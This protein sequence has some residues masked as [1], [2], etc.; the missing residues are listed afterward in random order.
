MS[1]EQ[2]AAAKASRCGLCRAQAGEPCINIFRPGE[3]L[4]GRT[5]HWYRLPTDNITN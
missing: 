4:P 5:I 1:P 2:V 3:P